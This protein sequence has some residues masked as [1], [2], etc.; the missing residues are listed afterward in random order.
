MGDD[1]LKVTKKESRDLLTDE[2]VKIALQNDKGEGAELVAWEAK[3]FTKP[4]DNYAGVVTSAVVEYSLS[5]EKHQ[6]TYIAKLNPM[7]GIV[8]FESFTNNQFI[9]EGHYFTVFLPEMNELLTKYNQPP[10]R[11]AKG[12]FANMKLNQECLI[13]EDLRARGF[14]M[15]DRKRGV[16]RAHGMLVVNEL[17]RLHAASLLKE[18]YIGSDSFEKYGVLVNEW[19]ELK[20]DPKMTDMVENMFAG[21]LEAAIK[22]LE[23]ISGYEKTVD[24]IKKLQP[25]ILDLV[26]D[27]FK[28]T[29]KFGVIIHG[30]CWNN[31][32]LF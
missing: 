25:I 2:N 30:D 13:L 15:F 1:N 24:W 20:S 27:L 9:R 21:N 16:D 5:G 7:R 8:L 31:N 28:I 14:K 19:V 11:L 10:L 17:G 4:G 3:D 22:L 29:E 12:Y 6:V 26:L 32:I 18:K 23:T